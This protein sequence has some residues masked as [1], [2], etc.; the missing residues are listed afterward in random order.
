MVGMPGFLRFGVTNVP[1]SPFN[2]LTQNLINMLLAQ[3]T[4][5]WK[6][7]QLNFPSERL[8][9]KTMAKTGTVDSDWNELMGQRL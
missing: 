1:I 8:S 2:M 3:Y 6:F 4:L 9:H 5:H 7:M